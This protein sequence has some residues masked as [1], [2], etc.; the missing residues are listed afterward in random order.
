MYPLEGE[1]TLTGSEYLL[2]RNQGCD[3]KLKE[4]YLIPQQVCKLSKV[5]F[6]SNG[7]VPLL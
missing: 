1:A 7:E 5:V 4:I 6:I 2:A 3:I